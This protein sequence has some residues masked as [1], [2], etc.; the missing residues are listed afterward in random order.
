MPSGAFE[1]SS[2]SEWAISAAVDFAKQ[3][4][5]ALDIRYLGASARTC[6]CEIVDSDGR[7]AK[8]LG[9]GVGD[10]STASAIFE[11]LEHYFSY[12]HSA[13]VDTPI[14]ELD[15]S[16]SDADLRDSSPDFQ[17]ICGH[18]VVPL[19]RL[20]FSQVDVPGKVLWFP[21]FLADPDYRSLN[22]EE[23]A[24]IRRFFLMRY[25]TNS[26]IAS[27]VCQSDAVL[28]GLLEV[29]ERDAIGMELLRTVIKSDAH[30]VREVL[31]HSLPETLRSLVE[32]IEAETQ[33][34]ICFWD[35][36]TDLG[37][38]AILGSLSI[39]GSAGSRYFGSGASLSLLNAVERAML[40]TVQSFHAHDF[41]NRRRPRSGMENISGMPAYTRCLLEAGFFGYRGGRTY[42]DFADL[43][44]ISEG[45]LQMDTTRQVSY[46]VERLAAGGFK[47]Y[48]RPLIEGPINVTHVVVPRLERFHLVSY[49]VP[50]LPSARGRSALLAK[51]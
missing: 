48:W 26:G 1:R 43:S 3:S 11:A 31:R 39:G 27:G 16:G 8:G 13:V 33:G 35:I 49:G 51:S 21:A 38:P 50:V 17:T 19:A 10:Q 37:V 6:Y 45:L 42:V 22:A 5:L 30:P 28:H 18:G 12:A 23:F 34:A 24:A 9:K 20:R 41:H 29:I 40:E 36:T 14:H 44:S 25:S 47:S 4:G 7:K 46:I 32:S 15:L 2:S